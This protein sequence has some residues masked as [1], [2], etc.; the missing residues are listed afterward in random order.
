MTFG[1]A[2]NKVVEGKMI[3]RPEWEDE[4]VFVTLVKE[5]LSISKPETKQMDYL[6]V[7]LGDITAED[8]VIYEKGEMA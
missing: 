4:R 8:W 5:V 1:E 2:L 7:S 3:R 6:I